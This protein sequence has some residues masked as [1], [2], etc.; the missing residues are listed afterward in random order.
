D[1]GRDVA[2]KV[3]LPQH[4]ASPNLRQRFLEEAQVAGQLQHPGIAPV[5]ELGTLPDGRPFIAMKL[6]EGRTLADLLGV[7]RDLHE[8]LPRLLPVSEQVCQT[9]PSA[10]S[11]GVIPRDLKPATVM[12]APSGEVQVMAWGL[13]KV[14]GVAAVAPP[15][16]GVVQTTRS[17]DPAGATQV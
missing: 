8:D 16:P 6:I 5:H 3:L 11:R 7:R 13:A 9:V 17:Q 15:A 12:V 1:L 2:L 4:Q 10:L 14:L